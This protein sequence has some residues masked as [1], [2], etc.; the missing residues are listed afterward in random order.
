MPDSTKPG[1]EGP[2]A[3]CWSGKGP[4]TYGTKTTDLKECPPGDR[5]DP[6]SLGGWDPDP[7]VDP[8]GI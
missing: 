1:G 5:W 8:Y 3:L 4:G 6:P 2:C 7:L